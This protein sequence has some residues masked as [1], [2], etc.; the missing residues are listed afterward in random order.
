MSRVSP[1]AS[2]T[3]STR[4]WPEAPWTT[5]RNW[6]AASARRREPSPTLPLALLRTS[7]AHFHLARGIPTA[8]LREATA[9]GELVSPTIA[10]PYCCD[11]RSAQALALAALDRA[12]EA[13]ATAAAELA[14]A[15]TFGSSSGDR[16]LTAD[17]RSGDRRSRRRR[18]A[19]RGRGRHSRRP[20]AASTMPARCWSSA[21]RSVTKAPAPRPAT[22]CASRSTRLPAS[23]PAASPT[24]PTRSSS[25]RALGH[26]ETGACC[27][28]AS[29]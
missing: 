5:L 4:W 15:R 26:G 18:D 29:R 16:R 13:A 21:S 27:Q 14:D 20:R 11:W 25:P 1:G 23:A 3:C 19:A 10:N 2:R 12:D 24:A 9:A 7:L 6:W 28:G 17:P 8:A 22:L